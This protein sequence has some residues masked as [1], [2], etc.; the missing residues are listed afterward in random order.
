MP[1]RSQVERV[2]SITAR[3]CAAQTEDGMA[4]WENGF[5]EQSGHTQIT[6][7]ILVRDRIRDPETLTHS[8]KRAS[9]Y[10]VR[11]AS[12]CLSSCFVMDNNYPSSQWHYLLPFRSQ[13]TIPSFPNRTS[14]R[15]CVLYYYRLH[16][17]KNRRLARRYSH[18]PR[19]SS[20]CLATRP[21]PFRLPKRHFPRPPSQFRVPKHP[22]TLLLPLKI[23]ILMRRYPTHSSRQHYQYKKAVPSQ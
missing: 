16:S 15:H 8:S 21:I 3:H 9:G 7:T 18:S 23:R 17:G 22:S 4:A 12:T 10:S 14:H 5:A 1:C 20:S 2:R 11:S 6:I 13:R 19:L